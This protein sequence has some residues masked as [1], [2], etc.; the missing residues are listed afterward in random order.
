LFAKIRLLS[1]LNTQ[2]RY[3]NH[4]VPSPVASFSTNALIGLLYFLPP[5]L[6]TLSI[7]MC[8]LFVTFLYALFQQELSNRR[9]QDRP[10]L[11]GY[12]PILPKSNRK[13]I[14]DTFTNTP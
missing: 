10:M 8:L 11:I 13:S 3:N 4:S 6:R 7:T 1:C 5:N 9:L 2:Q 12:L 14:G